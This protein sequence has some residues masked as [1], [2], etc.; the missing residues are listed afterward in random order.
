MFDAVL[1]VTMSGSSCFASL[2]NP[3]LDFVEKIVLAFIRR[4][5]SICGYIEATSEP[6]MVD[7]VLLDW[8]TIIRPVICIF[9]SLEMTIKM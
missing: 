5:L 9:S 6:K 2:G 8:P 3:S 4:R 1:R 7:N